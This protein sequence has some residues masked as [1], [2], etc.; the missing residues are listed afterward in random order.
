MRRRVFFLSVVACAAIALLAGFFTRAVGAGDGKISIVFPSSNVYVT[1]PQIEVVGLVKG[2]AA[3]QVRVAVKGGRAVGGETAPVVKNAFACAIELKPGINQ[4]S[5]SDAAGISEGSSVSVFFQTEGNQ[6]T[7][8]AEFSP[9]YLHSPLKKRACEECH[10]LGGAVPSYKRMGP[11]ATCMSGECHKTMGQAAFVHGPVAGGTCVA[12]HNPHGSK[13]PYYRARTDAQECYVCHEKQQ[14]DFA[15]AN[16]HKPVANGHCIDC[17]DPHQSG[18]KFQLKAASIQGLC[19]NCHD[20]KLIKEP[21]LHGPVAAGGCVVCHN[22]HAAN[23]PKLL[24]NE[25]RVLCFTCHAESKARFEL[26]NTHKPVTESCLKCH[27]PHGSIDP[28]LLV[29][30]ESELCL[31][32]HEKLHPAVAKT[33]KDS[34]VKHPPVAEGKCVSCHTPHSTNFEKQLKASMQT[35]CFTCH[36]EVGQ[37][38]KTSK[39]PHGPVKDNDC[40]ACHISHG[41]NNPKILKNYFPDEFYT[42]YAT[43]KYAICFDCHNKNIA[44][45]ELTTTLTNFRNGNRNLH[46]LHVNKDPK[47]RSCKA[48]HEVHAGNQAKHIREE[49]PFGSMWSY[50]INYT[51]LETGGRCLVGCH[52]PKEYDRMNPVAY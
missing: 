37:S 24:V 44:L 3:S 27:R 48:C 4:I 12:C 13:N 40:Y 22:P 30:K 28:M 35:I 43:E 26:K 32:C 36:A 33:I 25:E 50:P 21:Y 23:Q 18:T 47:G 20:G 7:R 41:S 9:Y 2:T 29:K 49:V 52:K 1:Q 8:P 15:K 34:T 38:V 17:H 6:K 42:A 10:N 51:K 31:S 39:Y 45:E 11:S 14:T 46:F 5:I 19:F 16:K